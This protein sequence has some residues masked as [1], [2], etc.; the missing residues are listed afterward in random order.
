MHPKRGGG[1]TEFAHRGLR[2]YA[3]HMPEVSGLSSY[4][5]VCDGQGENQIS[6][7]FA[8]SRTSPRVVVRYANAGST[9]L[10][11]ERRTVRLGVLGESA[12]ADAAA[13]AA[14]LAAIGDAVIHRNVCCPDRI[15]AIAI[16]AAELAKNTS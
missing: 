3:R 13:L 1:V 10:A 2:L 15:Y 7:H 6:Y 14:A 12:F 5:H 4:L 8:V 9:C 16:N 11:P